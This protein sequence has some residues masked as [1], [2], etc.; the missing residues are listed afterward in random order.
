MVEIS[1]N[2]A[3]ALSV[4]DNICCLKSS[5]MAFA[6]GVSDVVTADLDSLIIHTSAR[7]YGSKVRK[8]HQIV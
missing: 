4:V 5:A 6:V 8:T 7:L 3:L 1:G 2:P